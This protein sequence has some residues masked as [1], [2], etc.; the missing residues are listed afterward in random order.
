M[1]ISRVRH[2]VSR[3]S[4][5]LPHLYLIARCKTVERVNMLATGLR[6]YLHAVC[7]ISEPKQAVKHQAASQ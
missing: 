6:G 1:L 7:D 4:V 3:M 2:S 5:S